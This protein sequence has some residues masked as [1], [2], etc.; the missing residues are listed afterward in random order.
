MAL[1]GLYRLYTDT[2]SQVEVE[3]SAADIHTI[4]FTNISR[5]AQPEK[6]GQM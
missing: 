6:L 4:A 3:V 5:A 1:Y 2:H